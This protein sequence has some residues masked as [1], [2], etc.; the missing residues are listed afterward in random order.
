M[1]SVAALLAAS[2]LVLLVACAPDR[3]VE[4]QAAE[5]PTPS[6]EVAAAR[7]FPSHAGAPGSEVRDA[8]EA[9]EEAARKIFD[10]T[11]NAAS[12]IREAGV[13][14]VQAVRPGA[15]EVADANPAA[16]S[17]SEPARN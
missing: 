16:V 3:P 15:E 17:E 1:K 9:A 4:P 5:T 10:A 11:L 13:D 7:I 12:R 2:F 14:A 6:G 8:R